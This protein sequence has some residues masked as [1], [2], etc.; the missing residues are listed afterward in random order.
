MKSKALNTLP[1]ASGQQPVCLV[2]ES[3]W[4]IK[5]L[6]GY[7]KI[8]VATLYSDLQR[9]PHRVPPPLPQRG[10]NGLRW[11]PVKVRAWFESEGESP[12]PGQ[13]TATTSK[14]HR[15]RGRPPKA[16]S[17]SSAGVRHGQG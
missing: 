15:K 8:A 13:E 16:R 3:L 4:T 12:C 17:A 7:S 14:P 6:S 9:A 11:N 2:C 5:D 1:L 10:R